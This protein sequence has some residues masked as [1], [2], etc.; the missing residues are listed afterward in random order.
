MNF[1][2]VRKCLTRF[3][4]YTVYLT[5]LLAYAFFQGSQY[6]W[7]EPDSLALLPDYS[8]AETLEPGDSNRSVF[9]GMAV[10]MA[11]IFQVVIG[12]LFSRK[13]AVLTIMLFGVI[14]VVYA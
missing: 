6:D 10:V 13:E 12:V 5:C 3:L 8:S 4:V 14:L 1:I 2:K 7:F 11:V 9:R